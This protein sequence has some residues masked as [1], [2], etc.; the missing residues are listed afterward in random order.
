[1]ARTK[2]T[3]RK[4][5]CGYIPG[6]LSEAPLRFTVTRDASQLRVLRKRKRQDEEQEQL[7][8][9]AAAIQAANATAL[10]ALQAERV[11]EEQ[12]GQQEEDLA[13]DAVEGGA[14]AG[15]G[16]AAGGDPDDGD[17]SNGS[18]RNDGAGDSEQDSNTMED[19]QGEEEEDPT[20]EY[21]T[22]TKTKITRDSGNSFFHEELMKMLWRAYGRRQASVEYSC[23]YHSYSTTRYPG[24]WEVL[25]KVRVSDGELEGAREQSTH[26]S[27]APRET[28][29]AGIQDAARRAFLVYND[30]HYHLIEHRRERYYPRRIPGGAG[31]IVASTMHQRRTTQD[32]TVNLSAV[33]HTELEHAIDEINALREENAR[34]RRASDMMRAELGGPVT[35]DESQD[36]PEAPARPRLPYGSRKARTRMDL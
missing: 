36:V 35:L 4:R 1:M 14:G 7:A 30:K 20:Q 5:T 16:A 25:C 6:R 10:A 13:Q 9:A 28:V 15:Q 18:D 24:R 33:L 29:E 22:K 27:A 32:A 17:D 12:S 11:G 19:E 21:W 2:Q 3:A 34:L 8:T 23:F 26:W 31:C